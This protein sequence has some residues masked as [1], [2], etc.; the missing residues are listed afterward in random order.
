MIGRRQERLAEQIREEISMIIAGEVEDPRAGLGE[1]SLRLVV[2][3]ADDQVLAED[4]TAHVAGD[5]ER[6][7]AEH[8]PLADVGVRRQ[9][10]A[11]ALGELLVVGHPLE[12]I[13]RRSRPTLFD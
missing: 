10:V 13:E 11:D 9:E 5:H 12:V 4:P 6:D 3:E 1:R 2:A 7:A 8:P